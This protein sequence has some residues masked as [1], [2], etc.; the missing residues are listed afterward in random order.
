MTTNHELK[1]LE[2]LLQEPIQSPD[3]NYA[4]DWKSFWE[5]KKYIKQATDDHFYAEPGKKTLAIDGSLFD[6]VPMKIESQTGWDSLYTIDGRTDAY[7]NYLGEGFNFAYGFDEFVFNDYTLRVDLGKN[8]LSGQLLRMYDALFDRDPVGSDP[9]VTFTLVNAEIHGLSLYEIAD[10]LITSH[11]F[12]SNYGYNMSDDQF[13]QT[14]YFNA[15]N[16]FPTEYELN[17]HYRPFFSNGTLDK[18][19]ALVN[20]VRADEVV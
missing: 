19:S 10:S 17:T 20:F 18:Q 13:V 6:Y 12:I 1:R 2:D 8:G 7:G 11:E 5:A 16:R 4:Y 15:L 3:T 14:I 9:G